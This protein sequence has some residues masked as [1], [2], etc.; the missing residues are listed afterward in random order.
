MS[1][2]ADAE[3]HAIECLPAESCGLVVRAADGAVLY[4]PCRNIAP[5]GEFQCHWDDLAR[6]EDLGFEILGV[7]HSHP[8]QRVPRPGAGDVAC[9]DAGDLPWHVVGVDG[10]AAPRWVDFEP[11]WRIAPLEGRVFVHGATDCYS[12][13]RDWYRLEHGVVLPDYPRADGWWDAGDDLYRQQFEDAGFREVA[14][15]PEPGDVLLMQIRAP[16]PNHGALY[17]GGDM[18]AHHLAGRLSLTEAW[19]GALRACTRII[20]RH[21]PTA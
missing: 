18:I 8:G 14:G 3:R 5:A 17:L 10:D 16:V 2:R 11:A 20:L 12:I 9:C 4:W 19:D 1:W 13:I 15:P 7:V 21:D 6:A